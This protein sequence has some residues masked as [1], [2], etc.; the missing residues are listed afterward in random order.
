VVFR[1]NVHL[2]LLLACFF[3]QATPLFHH[4]VTIQYVSLFAL[5][6][7]NSSLFIPGLLRTHSFVFFAV[8]SLKLYHNVKSAIFFV[9]V[10]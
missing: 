2:A 9:N 4:G 6:V 3:L 1:D 10:N 8:H 7:S 5:T